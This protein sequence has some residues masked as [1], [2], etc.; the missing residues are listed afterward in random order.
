MNTLLFNG[1]RNKKIK[2][3]ITEQNRIENI[4]NIYHT[5]FCQGL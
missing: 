3:I 5:D 2:E 4:G 1:K